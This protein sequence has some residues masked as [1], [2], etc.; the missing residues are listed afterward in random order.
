MVDNDQNNDEYKF[1][2]YDAMDHDPMGEMEPGLGNS[3]SQ[4]DAPPKKDIKRNALIAVGLIILAMLLYKLIGYLFFSEKTEPVVATIPPMTQ[5]NI[6]PETPKVVTPVPVQPVVTVDDV[7][8]KRRVSALE[9]SQ[10][11]IRSEVSNLS[12]QV[13]TLN[14][15]VTTITNQL[16]S[17]NE[18]ITNLSNQMAK[19]SDEISMLIARSQPKRVIK[20]V[21]RQIRQPVIYYLKAVIPGRAWLI[22][23]NGSTLTVRE[24][25][26]ITGYGSVRLIDAMQGRVLT[27]SGRVIRFSQEDS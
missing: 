2:E 24:G 23:T 25:T 21:V 20:P 3:L 15:N 12:Q 9:V 11:N 18:V 16:A 6:Q 13:V 27:S 17:L 19:Q 14:N 10:Q 4:D 7:D 1:A 22:G 8:L 5:T 26:K